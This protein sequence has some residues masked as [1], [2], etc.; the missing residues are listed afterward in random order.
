MLTVEEFMTVEYAVQLFYRP[1][2]AYKDV[3]FSVIHS[4]RA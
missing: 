2:R 1:L 4:W 3:Y